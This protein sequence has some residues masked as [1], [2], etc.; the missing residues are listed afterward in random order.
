MPPKSYGKPVVCEACSPVSELDSYPECPLTFLGNGLN[1]VKVMPESAI[2]FGSYEA[3]KRALAQLEGHNNPK[4][5]NPFSQFV[6]GGGKL[7]LMLKC[8]FPL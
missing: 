1:V 5:I 2:K 6:A 7:I 3:A 8:C 4:K